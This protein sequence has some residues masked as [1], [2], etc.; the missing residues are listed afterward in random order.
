VSHPVPLLGHFL[1]NSKLEAV[2][3]FSE[4]DKSLEFITLL[5]MKELPV[6]SYQGQYRLM[7]NACQI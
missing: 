7:K 6:A 4:T 3:Q 5:Q 1:K 2:L